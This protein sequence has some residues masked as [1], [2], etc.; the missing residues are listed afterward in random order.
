MRGVAERAPIQGRP[1]ASQRAAEPAH[2]P[3]A[4]LVF[5]PRGFKHPVFKQRFKQSPRPE[6]C[7]SAPSV[8]ARALGCGKS[9]G[10]AGATPLPARVRQPRAAHKRASSKIPVLVIQLEFAG[11]LECS[12]PHASAGGVLCAKGQGRALQAISW[13]PSTLNLSS[14]THRGCPALLRLTS[15][16][17]YAMCY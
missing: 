4:G 15:P 14:R 7:P 5:F 6:S 9:L 12:G 1:R 3:A 2:L 16:P 13:R 10:G 17:R 8:Q 11:W